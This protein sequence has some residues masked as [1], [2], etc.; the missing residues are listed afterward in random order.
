[1]DAPSVVQLLAGGAIGQLQRSSIITSDQY[2]SNQLAKAV[3]YSDWF[4]GAR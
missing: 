1:M 2:Y 3:E 4:S